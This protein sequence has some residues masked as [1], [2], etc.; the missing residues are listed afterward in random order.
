MLPPKFK[1][2]KRVGGWGGRPPRQ[3]VVQ[4]IRH[5]ALSIGELFDFFKEWGSLLLLKLNLLKCC[6]NFISQ[7]Y[8]GLSQSLLCRKFLFC[9]FI[10]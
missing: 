3:T 8:W 1:S 4:W 9:I 7:I 6:T 5:A 2:S 10:F